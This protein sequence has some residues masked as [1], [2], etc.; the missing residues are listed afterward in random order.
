MIDTRGNMTPTKNMFTFIKADK[1]WNVY[2]GIPV[3]ICIQKFMKTTICFH[4][5]FCKKKILAQ[6][7][8]GYMFDLFFKFFFL[9]IV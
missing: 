6:I 9:N 1:I 3:Q 7:S 5:K 4:I 2:S 8:H